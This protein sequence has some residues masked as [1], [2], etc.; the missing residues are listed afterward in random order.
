M[1]PSCEDTF[2]NRQALENLN[3]IRRQVNQYVG[4]GRANAAVAVV[5]G[6]R[7]LV[8]CG[9]YGKITSDQENL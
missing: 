6:G 4:A 9:G 7:R 5:E 2:D 1:F 8:V 3:M